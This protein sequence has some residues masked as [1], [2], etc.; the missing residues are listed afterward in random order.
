MQ[1][2]GVGIRR[3][4]STCELDILDFDD[5]TLSQG[6]ST[7]T[8]SSTSPVCVEER[9]NM[10]SSWPFVKPMMKELI[11]QSIASLSP[12]DRGRFQNF[13]RES[14]GT[15]VPLSLSTLCSGTDGAVDTLKAICWDV[16]VSVSISIQV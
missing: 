11:C 4:K 15:K 9:A 12:E 6:A 13:G 3:G 16:S 10:M 8:P 7:T 5:K 1:D 14:E 2:P